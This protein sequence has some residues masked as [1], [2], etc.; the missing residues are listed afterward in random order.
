MTG[1]QDKEG[2]D[3]SEDTESSESEDEEEGGTETGRGAKPTKQKVMRSQRRNENLMASQKNN[4]DY[5]KK[6]KNCKRDTLDTHYKP[7]TSEIFK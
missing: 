2:E 4:P 6:V 3:S 1:G 5:I 7:D